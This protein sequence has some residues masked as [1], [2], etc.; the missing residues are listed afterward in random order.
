LLQCCEIVIGIQIGQKRWKKHGKFG[1]MGHTKARWC[2]RY[3][4]II[5]IKIRGYFVT[6]EFG[7]DASRSTV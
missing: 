4:M 7:S 2:N 3:E 5:R 6:R 1:S